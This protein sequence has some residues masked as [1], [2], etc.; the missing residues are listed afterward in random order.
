VRAVGLAIAS[1][2]PGRSGIFAFNAASPA[3]VM[4]YLAPPLASI[5]F[6]IQ[7]FVIIP[8]RVTWPAGYSCL[9]SSPSYDSVRVF[10][11][12]AVRSALNRSSV[13]VDVIAPSEM[14][15]LTGASQSWSNLSA[16]LDRRDA[17]QNPGQRGRLAPILFGQRRDDEV[18]VR[19]NGEMAVERL[20]YP[21]SPLVKSVLHTILIFSNP[22]K[23]RPMAG[24]GGGPC[25]RPAIA[26]HWP[27]RASDFMRGCWNEIKNLCDRDDGNRFDIG[28]GYGRAGVRA[29]WRC[30]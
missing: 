18:D 26:Q 10:M 19:G 2:S 28:S 24:C 29:L 22:S 5:C 15:T 1:P 14:T 16:E 20:V 7:P 11:F 8:S 12:R 4:R 17:R 6:S 3:G 27:T 9:A 30:D 25:V 23:F 21:L 13:H